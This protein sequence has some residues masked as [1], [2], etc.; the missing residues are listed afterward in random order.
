MLGVLGNVRKNLVCCG[1]DKQ[2]LLGMRE[3]VEI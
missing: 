1:G 2:I 3:I